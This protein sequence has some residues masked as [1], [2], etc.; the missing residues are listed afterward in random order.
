M[1]QPEF[2]VVSLMG[3]K[4]SGKST[5]TEWLE[6][7]R[8]FLPAAFAT[9][10]KELVLQLFP[11]NLTRE[12]LYGPHE[13]RERV[14]TDAVRRSL[15]TEFYSA[16]TYLR[17]D[18]DGRTTVRELFP[19]V[20]PVA[21]ASALY[22]AFDPFEQTLRSPRTILQTLGTEW[23]RRLDENAWARALVGDLRK[24]GAGRYAVSDC[25][26]LNEVTVLAKEFGAK[27]YWVER[28]GKREGVGSTHASEPVKAELLGHCAG[29][30]DN[31]GSEEELRARLETLFPTA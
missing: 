4:G 23:G 18:A 14:F 28:G 17:L 9:P 13:E 26:F 16:A 20:T 2:T 30:I 15:V 12:V 21:A 8:Q 5:I 27:T 1:N 3:L 22:R 24:R 29:E 31:T 10:L 19:E 6:K 7:H 11:R 25:R